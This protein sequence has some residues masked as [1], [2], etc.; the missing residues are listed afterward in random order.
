VKLKNPKHKTVYLDVDTSSSSPNYGNIHAYQ[1]ALMPTAQTLQKVNYVFEV[2]G[3]KLLADIK[4][5]L[6]YPKSCSDL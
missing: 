2:D 4:Q 1:E 5:A 6:Q 3:T